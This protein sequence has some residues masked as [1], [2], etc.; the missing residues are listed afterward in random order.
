LLS[1]AALRFKPKEGFAFG[2]SL[3]WC[4][5]LLMASLY[6]YSIY[7]DDWAFLRVLSGFNLIALILLFSQQLTPPR[8]FT[9][10]S[11][12]LVFTTIGRLLLKV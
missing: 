11:A 9:I 10:T 5:A 3:S 1:S 7:V 8:S 4:A 6:T 2:L 12:I